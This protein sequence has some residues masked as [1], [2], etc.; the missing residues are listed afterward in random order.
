MKAVVDVTNIT[1]Q[2]FSCIKYS[3]VT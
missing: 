1:M 3:A 2:I